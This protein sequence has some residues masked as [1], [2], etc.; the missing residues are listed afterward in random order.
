M[1]ENNS[2]LIDGSADILE[3]GTDFFT[4]NDAVEDFPIIGIAVKIGFAVKS[5][6]DRIK[7]LSKKDRQV[8][9]VLIN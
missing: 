9:S 3:Y 8:M 5:I 4:E 1:D 2:N 7:I 6:S